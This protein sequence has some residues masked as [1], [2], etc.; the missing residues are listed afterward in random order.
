MEFVVV[1]VVEDE[2]EEAAGTVVSV[3]VSVVS[4]VSVVVV[5]SPVTSVVVVTDV[6]VVDDSSSVETVEMTMSG[7]STAMGVSS[8]VVEEE[9]VLVVTVVEA[10][11]LADDTASG[12]VASAFPSRAAMRLLATSI[13][14]RARFKRAVASQRGR[15]AP[16]LLRVPKFIW[17]S[18]EPVM[19]KSGF[20]NYF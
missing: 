19:E 7:P 20:L 9:E 10:A 17:T 3:V 6:T 11:A 12:V 13:T 4:I 16:G 1:E 15:D 14:R 2:V 18:T 8:S 5:S